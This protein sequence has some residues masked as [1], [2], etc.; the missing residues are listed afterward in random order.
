[1]ERFSTIKERKIVDKEDK[2]RH[3]V[4]LTRA[5]RLSLPAIVEERKIL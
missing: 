4:I 2:T 3:R 5:P 1:M